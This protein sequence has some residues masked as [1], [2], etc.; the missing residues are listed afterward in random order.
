MVKKKLNSDLEPIYG[1]IDY[2]EDQIM[3]LEADINKL[4]KLT[5]W[6]PIVNLED[7]IQKTVEYFK[8]Y[9]SYKI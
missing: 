2:R 6:M 9:P 8:K 5:G 1:A 3:H 7:G 4:K